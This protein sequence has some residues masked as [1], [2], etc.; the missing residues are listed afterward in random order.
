MV[1]ISELKSNTLTNELIRIDFLRIKNMNNILD[2][3]QIFMKNNNFKF[4][5]AD[6]KNVNINIE[7]PESLITQEMI[8][9]Q[10]DTTYNYEFIM[11]D[12][13]H[14]YVLN[15]YFLIFEKERVT[16]YEKIEKY[17]EI[18]EKILE[19]IFKYEEDINVSRIGIR[20]ENQ[21]FVLNSDT[22][23]KYTNVSLPYEDKKILDEYFVI[24]KN[25]NDTGNISSNIKINL[26]RGKIKEPKDG[27][28][29]DMYRFIWDID[30]Y[31]RDVG[32]KDNVLSNIKNLN[33]YLFKKYEYIMSDEFMKI[34]SQEQN[35]ESLRKLGIYGG[36]ASNG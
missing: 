32:N 2:E 26:K 28:L 13:S 16:K 20:K 15:E 9:S 19:I 4:R 10:I 11:E 3:L 7:D 8:K 24:Q 36:I 34:L 12:E 27:M 1:E 30:C 17:L 25:L 35:E 18:Y 29:I 21:L 31:M 22:L 23:K 6:I 14:K 5:T 33:S